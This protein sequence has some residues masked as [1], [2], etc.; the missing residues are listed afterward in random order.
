MPGTTRATLALAA[1]IVLLLGTG[2][3][4]AFTIDQQKAAG[5]GGRAS[6]VPTSLPPPPPPPVDLGA[7]V[8]P[9]PTGFDRIPDATLLVGGAADADR[10]VVERTDQ[11]RARAVFTETGLVSGF[12]R[13]WQRPSTSELVTVRLYQFTTPEGAKAY[14]T[15]VISAMSTAPA[16]TFVV[17]ATTDTT[18]IDSQVA[19][20]PNRL[21]YVVERKGRVV[22]AL[23]AT[24]TPPPEAG[25]LAPMARSQLSLLP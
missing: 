10:L 12:V 1:C 21:V 16:R 14:A 23:A 9:G 20:G 25:F 19:Q 8:V 22:A 4:G 2:V 6:A 17:P 5:R 15:K 13:A 3:V 24:L 18:G 7:I 11:T